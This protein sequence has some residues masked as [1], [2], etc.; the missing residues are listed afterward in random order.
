[1]LTFCHVHQ[2]KML[3]LLQQ[4]PQS[5]NS[6]LSSKTLFNLCSIT[7][8]LWALIFV[9]PD[10]YS[11]HYLGYS[12]SIFPPLSSRNFRVSSLTVGL[13][14]TWPSFFV[15]SEREGCYVISLYNNIHFFPALFVKDV[16]F[17]KSVSWHLHQKRQRQVHGLIP[18]SSVLLR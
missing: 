16:V 6:L 15:Q 1:M 11:E 10:C 7:C 18:K 5:V 14:P 17:S 3:P 12:Q 2:A 8:Q 13:W 9:L 4:P